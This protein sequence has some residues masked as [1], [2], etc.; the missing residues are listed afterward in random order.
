M[1]Q[2]AGYIVVLQLIF[3]VNGRRLS[4][5]LY[6]YFYLSERDCTSRFL[7]IMSKKG[8]L[9]ILLLLLQVP[10]RHFNCEDVC[11]QQTKQDEVAYPWGTEVRAFWALFPRT[12]WSMD[13]SSASRS[14]TAR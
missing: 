3:L 5:F 9:L 13:L 8:L 7:S 6:V 12:Y 11:R 2:D 4:I 10:P 1:N 14:S